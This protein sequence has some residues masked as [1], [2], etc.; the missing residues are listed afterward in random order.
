MAKALVEQN[1]SRV[2]N[3][4]LPARRGT[5]APAR[6]PPGLEKSPRPSLRAPAHPEAAPHRPGA[7]PQASKLRTAP[8]GGDQGLGSPGHTA[9][10]HPATPALRTHD[11]RLAPVPTSNCAPT[12]NSTNAIQNVHPKNTQGSPRGHAIP[13]TRHDSRSP[14]LHHAEKHRHP[15]TRTHTHAHAHTHSRTLRDR[16][17]LTPVHTT[18]L[19]Q[20]RSPPLPYRL[21]CRTRS[22]GFSSPSCAGGGGGGRGP[23]PRTSAETRG[24]AKRAGFREPAAAARALRASPPRKTKGSRRPREGARG[25]RPQV[26]RSSACRRRGP[27]ASPGRKGRE[28]GTRR[29]GPGRG[30]RPGAGTQVSCEPAPASTTP[31]NQLRPPDRGPATPR[32]WPRPPVDLELQTL[33]WGPAP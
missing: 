1:G 30:A 6:E 29:R 32:P 20:S 13:G 9:H 10:A 4:C 17:Q 2:R 25:W 11:T 22:A 7:F 23:L 8:T 28:G 21:R 33:G 19:P 16:S 24:V 14:K 26:R 5:P 12:H 15:N 31:P 3:R 18:A 27:P